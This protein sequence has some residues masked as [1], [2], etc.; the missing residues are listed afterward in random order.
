MVENSRVIVATV[1]NKVTWHLNATQ[2]ATLQVTRDKRKR[3][4]ESSVLTATS[5]Q[6]TTPKIAE[7][8]RKRRLTTERKKQE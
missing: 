3:R 4:P 8:A 5:L 2:R 1:E 6:G 7:R